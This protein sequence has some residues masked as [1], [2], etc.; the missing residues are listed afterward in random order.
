MF[1]GT[2]LHLLVESPYYDERLPPRED[3]PELDFSTKKRLIA[4]DHQWQE[5]RGAET[6]ALN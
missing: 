3:R 6:K 2:E 5:V 4:D 1:S